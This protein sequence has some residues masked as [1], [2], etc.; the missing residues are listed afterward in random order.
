MS[1]IPSPRRFPVLDR[2]PFAGTGAAWGIVAAGF[3]AVTG[4]GSSSSSSTQNEGDE[5]R[6]EPSQPAAGPGGSDDPASRETAG[7]GEV[8]PA[9]SGQTAAAGG[10]ET[11]PEGSLPQSLLVT[12]SQFPVGPDG[13]ATAK[14][15][16]ALLEVFSYR[17]GQWTH[18]TLE[19]SESNV[20]HKALLLEGSGPAAIVTLGAEDAAVKRWRPEGDG[21]RGTTI[22]TE[23]FGGRFDRMRD[24][25]IGDV[26]GDGAP[27][28]VVGTHDQGVVA[29]LDAAG[30]AGEDW[31]STRLYE[32]ENTFI[33]EI[34]LADLDGNG[35]LEI[36][37]TPSEPN[38]LSG[39]KAQRGTVIRLSPAGGGEATVVADLGDRHAKE[40]L[41]EDVDGDGRDE[42]YVAVEGKTEGSGPNM[43]VVEPVEIR[44]YDAG[45][46][47]AEG[48]VIAR[49]DGERFTRFLTAGDVDGDGKKEMVAASFRQGLWLLRPGSDPRGEWGVESIDRES[50][51]FEHAAL[52]ADL[53]QD[54]R[55]ELYVAADE[56]GELRRYRWVGGRP[57]RE[58]IARRE[59]PAS[60]MTWNIT[61]APTELV[62][63]AP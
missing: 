26:D 47:P 42:L 10:G 18:R 23:E 33:H 14:P 21:Y 5:G 38:D 32:E 9:T 2:H 48:A 36:Y 41:V 45:T 51:G 8:G 13:K 57:R 19:D 35:R 24:A 3:L 22:W 59:V 60:R 16:A 55:D 49:I 52:L 39:D 27:E 31:T 11:S 44:R 53:D 1:R 54:G 7:A 34:E 6:G 50:S 40:I 43:R 12:Y 28:I 25:E 58:T 30:G 37:A 20:F 17:D 15:G 56:Q 46:D 63:P 4:C 61:A 62:A 29:L